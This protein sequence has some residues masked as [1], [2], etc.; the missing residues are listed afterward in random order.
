[1]SS[2]RIK[3]RKPF[4]AP[5]RLNRGY[6]TDK[7]YLVFTAIAVAIILLVSAILFREQL[8][9]SREWR[10]FIGGSL[11]YTITALYLIFNSQSFSLKKQWR[12]NLGSL[13]VLVVILGFPV[14]AFF[15]IFYFRFL[16][17]PEGLWPYWLG[18]VIL[19]PLMIECLKAMLPK[20]I[21]T[22]KLE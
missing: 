16:P 2:R 5:G 21:D 20:L 14:Y 9:L 10:L 17:L 6:L 13:I 15:L 22:K 12:S 4:L 11:A 18:G 3:M 1:M 19:A 7:I 8:S